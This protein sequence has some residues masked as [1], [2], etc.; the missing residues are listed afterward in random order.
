VWLSLKDVCIIFFDRIVYK[1][2]SDLCENSQH[3]SR[4]T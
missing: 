1:Y 3:F 2:F 4:C